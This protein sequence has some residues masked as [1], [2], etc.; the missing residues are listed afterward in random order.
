MSHSNT[1]IQS[2]PGVGIGKDA[3]DNDVRVSTNLDD[4]IVALMAYVYETLPPSP[5]NSSED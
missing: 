4:A 3:F 5:E 2:T 1:D